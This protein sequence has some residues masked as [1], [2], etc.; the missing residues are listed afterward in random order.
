MPYCTRQTPSLPHAHAHTHL[1]LRDAHRELGEPLH[2][3]LAP[4]AG[5]DDEHVQ[6]R[7]QALELRP[8]VRL[9]SV[10]A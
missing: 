7:E 9:L 5:P 10:R 3:R 1:A 4:E 8:H 2:V 6:P